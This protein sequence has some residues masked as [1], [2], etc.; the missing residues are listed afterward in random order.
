MD[1]SLEHPKRGA[2]S[3]EGFAERIGLLLFRKEKKL[4]SP[5]VYL[6]GEGASTPSTWQM[7]FCE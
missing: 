1:W 5:T 4:V 3:S 6:K 2:V 7:E